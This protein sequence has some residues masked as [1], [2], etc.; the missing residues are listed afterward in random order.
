MHPPSLL[1]LLATVLVLLVSRGTS[2]EEK[3]KLYSNQWAVEVVGGEEEAK[4]LAQSHGFSY[5]GKILSGIYLFEHRAVFK[6]SLRQNLQRHQRLRRE[7][8][9]RWLEQ[10]EIKRR[11][12]RD[13]R[14]KRTIEFSDPEWSAMWYLH[15]PNNLDMNVIPAWE[16]GYTGQGVVVTILDDGIERDHPDL[17]ENYDPDASYDVNAD[18]PDPMPRYNPSNENRHGTRCAGE[19][20]SVANNDV[21]GVGIAYHSRIG[22]VRMLD[23]D[24]TDAVE[25]KSIGLRPEHID[26]YSASWGPDDDGR[27]VDG[28]ASLAKAAFETGI[29][30]GRGGKGSIFVWASGN[31][32]RDEDSCNCDGYTNS[33]YTMSVS[34]ASERGNIPWYLEKC[35]STLATTYSSGSGA[36]RQ[37]V[38][39]DL[40]HRCTESHTGTSASAPL[41]AAIV[42]L[43]LEA[44]PNLSWRD[45]Q[46]IVV[47]TARPDNLHADDFTTNAAGYKVSH[48]FGFGLMDAGAMVNLAERWQNVPPQ[49]VCSVPGMNR[50][51]SIPASNRLVLHKTTDGCKDTNKE[52]TRLEHVQAR[53]TI[54]TMRRGELQIYLISPSGTRST[55]L[56]HRSRD[57]SASGFNGWEFMTTHT[58]DENPE[59]TWTL[60]INNMDRHAGMLKEWTLVLRGTSESQGHPSNP[61]TPH[62]QLCTQTDSNGVC[63]EGSTHQAP[64]VTPSASTTIKQESTS[65]ATSTAVKT[66]RKSTAVKTE[67]VTPSPST[68]TLERST[69]PTSTPSASTTIKQESTSTATSTAVKTERKS[70]AVKTEAIPTPGKATLE[71]KEPNYLLDDMCVKT[72]PNRYYPSDS[73]DQSQGRTCESCDKTC[74]TCSG[75]RPYECLTCGPLNHLFNS[76]CFP[77]KQLPLDQGPYLFYVAAVFFCVLAVILF[78]VIFGVLH[79]R[80]NSQCCFREEV[81]YVDLNGLGQKDRNGL[82]TEGEMFLSSDDEDLYSR[83]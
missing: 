27:T 82:V 56:D 10:Q 6:R 55:L 53:L 29:R 52:V 77:M 4:K 73:S 15:N 71:C 9:V 49:R 64:Q 31:G 78:F 74:L 8:T 75:A 83:D 35:S 24:V 11:I 25:A 67:A 59:G 38:S 50:P 32:G 39:T 48:A 81:Q 60:E 1:L 23:G 20:S 65:T 69:H 47:R 26:V 76:T 13:F 40:R 3:P 28:P 5:K 46:H 80:T 18:D 58:W 36:E 19:V 34:S 70:T 44:N 33:I 41:A 37:I 17:E 54:T 42:A 2:G 30:E 12:K 45:L 62:P 66:E 14:Q 57:D 43:T 68:A 63:I 7:P 16:K 72:C 61:H 21:C 22:G 79:M 51:T